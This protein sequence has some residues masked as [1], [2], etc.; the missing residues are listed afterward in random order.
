[1]AHAR[2]VGRELQRALERPN[3]LLLV[4]SHDEGAGE[5]HEHLGRGRST[6]DAFLAEADASLAIP[7][8]EHQR[9]PVI[10]EHARVVQVAP[11]RFF[12]DLVRRLRVGVEQRAAFFDD[13]RELRRGE[14]LVMRRVRRRGRQRRARQSRGRARRPG[15]DLHDGA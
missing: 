14:R 9:E 7:L 12:E 11:V 3:G 2:I 6:P 8:D 15:G 1:M 5:V 10:G 13:L 4:A